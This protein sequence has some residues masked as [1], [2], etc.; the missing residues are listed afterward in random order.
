MVVQIQDQTFYLTSSS[1]HLS[2]RLNFPHTMLPRFLL[3]NK[4]HWTYLSWAL[5]TIL[6]C[7]SNYYFKDRGM[8]FEHTFLRSTKRDCQLSTLSTF[9]RTICLQFYRSWLLLCYEIECGELRKNEI[10]NHENL[11]QS[12]SLWNK[13]NSN[14]KPN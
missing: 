6:I 11:P 10:D 2:I 1:Q 7:R 9:D 4:C 5:Y 12:K 8:H 13:N 3:K 14:S